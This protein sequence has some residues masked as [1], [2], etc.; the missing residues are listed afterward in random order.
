MQRF[1]SLLLASPRLAALILAAALA[2]RVLVP[3]GFMPD[4]GSA[5]PAIMMCSGTGPVA[6]PAAFQQEMA[7]RGVVHHSGQDSEA[8]KGCAFADLA[9][10]LLG[11]ADP[12][13]LV[14]ALLF[15]VAAALF[16]R[17][18]LPHAASPRLRPPL[19]APPSSL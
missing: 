7:A 3:A 18:A 13:L 17:A 4:F 16:H 12:V 8:A 19:R 9:L 14:A 10:P 15:L 11:G 6:A 2:L 1:R 5:G